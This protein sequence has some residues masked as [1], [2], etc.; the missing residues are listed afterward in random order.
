MRN[1][2]AGYKGNSSGPG[3]IAAIRAAAQQAAATQKV[4]LT[5]AAVVVNAARMLLG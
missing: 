5:Q 2:A 3:D 4:S 1:R